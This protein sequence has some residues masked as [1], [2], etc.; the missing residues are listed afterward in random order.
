MS[1]AGDIYQIKKQKSD[2]ANEKVAQKREILRENERLSKDKSKYSD[3]FSKKVLTNL[4][5]G[6]IIC[7]HEK[8][9]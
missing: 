9:L 5:T 2:F 1:G 4:M 3:F 8:I 7:E 6:D